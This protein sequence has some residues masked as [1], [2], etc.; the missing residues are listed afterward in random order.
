[1]MSK[2]LFAVNPAAGN[3]RGLQV[4]EQIKRLPELE[5]ADYRVAF[6]REAG[7]LP[8]LVAKKLKRFTVDRIIAVGGDGTVAEAVNGFAPRELPLGVIPAGSGNDF[9][10]LHGIPTDP[11]TA[12]QDAF[13]GTVHRV[14]LGMV[15]MRYFINVGGV[16]FDAEVAAE[17]NRLGKKLGSTLPYVFSLVRTLADY[18]NPEVSVKLDEET[19]EG[20][21]LLVAV[22]NGQFF[23]GGMHILPR[24]DAGDGL[25]DVCIGGDLSKPEIMALLP[26]IFRGSHVGH[27]K[28][29]LKRAQRVSIHTAQPV[30][31]HAD[32]EL[33]GTTPVEFRV[34]PGKLLLL[35]RSQGRIHH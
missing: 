8:A 12:L 15:D 11:R 34:F 29:Q 23:G 10:R 20:K 3:G 16:G 17:T 5:T 19:I 9:A 2:T 31:F 1:M 22:G 27:P 25:L 18:K 13:T 14:D 33:L 26:R 30:H 6:S 24:A 4:W 32:G 35:T 21:M 7:E 28:V